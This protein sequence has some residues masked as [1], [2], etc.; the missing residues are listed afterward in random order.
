MEVKLKATQYMEAGTY[1][2]LLSTYAL[3]HSPRIELWSEEGP[4]MTVTVNGDWVTPPGCV[5][6]KDYNEN[7]GIYQAF[8][9]AGLLEPEHTLIPA[10]YVYGVQ[11]KA[12]GALLE[13]INKQQQQH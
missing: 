2:L 9:D 13:L 11:C 5:T 6:V 1:E 4:M 8:V 3:G 10:G 12:K 7:T